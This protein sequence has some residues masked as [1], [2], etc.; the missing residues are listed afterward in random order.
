MQVE[1]NDKTLKWASGLFSFCSLFNT[2]V[3][4]KVV[5]IQESAAFIQGSIYQATM[6]SWTW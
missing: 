5:V 6:K 3:L 4:V 2:I 1:K